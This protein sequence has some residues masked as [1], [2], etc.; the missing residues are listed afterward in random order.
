MSLESAPHQSAQVRAKQQ[1]CVSSEQIIWAKAQGATALPASRPTRQPTHPEIPTNHSTNS[2][3]SSRSNH[4]TYRVGH[5][6]PFVA[7]AALNPLLQ[8]SRRHTRLNRHRY[9]LHDVRRRSK[10]PQCHQCIHLRVRLATRH[11][12]F[13]G[14]HE[15]GTRPRSPA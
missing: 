15:E 9:L 7:C 8:V 3:R 5:L 4:S 14:E 2:T 13:G 11:G 12:G 6:A 10:L 1:T